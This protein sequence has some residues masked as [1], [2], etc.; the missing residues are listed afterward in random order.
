MVLDYVTDPRP[1]GLSCSYPFTTSSVWPTAQLN[2]V[3]VRGDF[4]TGIQLDAGCWNS[5]IR[6][7]FI[8]G[9]LASEQEYANPQ[10]MKIGIDLQGAMDC[11]IENPRITSAAIGIRAS[12]AVG[13]FPRSEGLQVKGGWLMHVNTGIELNGSMLGG[14]PTPWAV[15]SEMH[16][17][18]NQF[19]VR[20]TGYSWLHLRELNCYGSH[21]STGKWC[22]YLVGCK[23]V[24]ITDCDFW[25]NW[26]VPGF[27]GGIVLDQCEN[28]EINGGSFVDSIT[29]A[30]HATPSCKGVRTNGKVWDK[31]IAQG[32][33]ANYSQP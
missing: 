32:K 14:W 2:N 26:S 1:V 16:L 23:N 15:L 9:N 33:V 30:L 4:H 13:D 21:Y 20:A 8:T 22:I 5:N 31:L 24:Q 28:V 10:V 11:H 12:T 18:F 29:L 19:A 3:V 27:F 6:D 17:A 25:T 7:C